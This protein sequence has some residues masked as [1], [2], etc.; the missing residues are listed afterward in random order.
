MS[1]KTQNIQMSL[2]EWETVNNGS[3]KNSTVI[4][5][6]EARLAGLRSVIA[7][8]REEDH[9]SG[10]AFLIFDDNLPEDQAYY[11]YPDGFIRI[12]QLDKRNIEIPRVVVKI[13]NRQESNAIRKKY[14]L[15][16]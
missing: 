10:H 6:Y 15:S 4:K 11:E 5:T 1:K 16:A 9:K 8:L 13:L 12:E 14:V 3:N 7:K 2:F